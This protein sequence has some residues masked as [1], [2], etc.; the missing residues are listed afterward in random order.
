M[1]H[2]IASINNINIKI[3]QDASSSSTSNI[4]DSFT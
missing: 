4:S 2:L 3:D 1:Y